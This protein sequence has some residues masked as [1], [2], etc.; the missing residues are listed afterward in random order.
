MNPMNKKVMWESFP[1]FYTLTFDG[2][3]GTKKAPMSSD[4]ER[5]VREPFS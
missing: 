3:G 1:F 4:R 5:R 2:F